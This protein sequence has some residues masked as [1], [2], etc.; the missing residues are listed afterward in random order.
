MRLWPRSIRWQMLAGLLLLE[1]LSIMLFAVL[2][3]SKQ[4]IEMR[5]RT[6]ERLANQAG[7]LALQ[8]REAI[9]E[10]KQGWVGLAVRTMGNSPNVSLAKVTDSLGNVLF[11][12]KGEPENLKL[13]PVERAQIP[14]LKKD[15]L[16]VFWLSPDHLESAAPIYTGG[17]L[18]GFTWIENNPAGADESRELIVRSTTFFAVI[19]IVAS[20]VLVYFAA[21]AIT[22]PL[23]VLHSGTRSLMNSPGSG[24]NFPL[25]VMV[26]NEFGDLIEAFNRMVASIDEQRSGLNDTLSLLDSML[27]NAPIGLA[28]LDRH[29][30]F[31]RV[32]QV[33]AE[34]TGVPLSRHLGRTLAE[35]LPQPMAQELEDAVTRVF[36]AE[37]PV[38][39]LELSGQGEDL[40]HSWTWLVSAYPV[41]TT[42]SQVRWAGVIVLDAS[43]RKR[44]EEALR[45]SEKLAAT[46][47]LAA[48]ISH[49][50]NNPLEA[51]T[52]LLYLLRNF[53]QLEG[54]A[55]N[56]VEMAEHEARRITEITQQ[57]LRFYR[58][59]TQPART[60]M[61]DILDSVL[62]LFQVRLNT[63]GI[64]LEREYDPEMDLFCFGGEVRQVI[65][66][67]VGNAIDATSGGGR[68][69]IRARRSR[70]WAGSGQEGVRIT[71]ADTGTGIEA[72]ARERI[73]EAFFTTKQVTGTGL[74]L[75]VSH[76]IILKHHGLVH[77]RSRPASAGGRSGTVFQLF[78]PDNQE[79]TDQVRQ[80]AAVEA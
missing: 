31:V 61:G 73:F 37:G 43:E 1:V 36:T 56:Y 18:R 64:R 80:A 78:L 58:Q 65:A 5:R 30:R 12:S 63:L 42:P 17:T 34:M 57:T 76:E 47:R 79:L 59:P 46:G 6:Q 50:I 44:S 38:R 21:R 48:S 67:L 19:W 22:Q 62:S 28:F 74:G 20:A 54:P 15:Q 60:N 51:I 7:S 39:N 33:F 45:R 25:P 10:N 69:I 13:D 71:V 2:L 41:R 16:K 3:V 70:Q 14:E 27:A 53:C 52:N 24:S 66:N 49:E 68:M 72:N 40:K 26:Q 35:V 11:S 55:L 9:Q 77:V 32:N 8:T 23:A 4:E 29:C 75:W